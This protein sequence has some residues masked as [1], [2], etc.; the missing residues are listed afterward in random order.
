[1]LGDHRVHDYVI[2]TVEVKTTQHVTGRLFITKLEVKSKHSLEY[3]K[4]AEKSR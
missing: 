1:M 4:E 3:E 2:N